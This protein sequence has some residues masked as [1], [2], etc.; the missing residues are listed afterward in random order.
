M[1]EVVKVLHDK[2]Y[3]D[4]PYENIETVKLTKEI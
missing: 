1:Q 3:I 4:E 2:G